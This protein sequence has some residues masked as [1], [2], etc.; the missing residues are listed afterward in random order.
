MITTCT[1]WPCYLPKHTFSTYL[2]ENANHFAFFSNLIGS[3]GVIHMHT[4]GT[5]CLFLTD[6]GTHQFTLCGCG[7]QCFIVKIWFKKMM[8]RGARTFL[9]GLLKMRHVRF[10]KVLNCCIRVKQKTVEGPWMLLFSMKLY[11][12]I[13]VLKLNAN[14]FMLSWKC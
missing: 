7:M 13:V 3:G 5:V 8:E 4:G 12:I 1:H 2:C 10:K 9:V 11:A 6:L 14:I